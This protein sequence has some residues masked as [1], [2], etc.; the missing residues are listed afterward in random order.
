MWDYNRLG[1]PINGIIYL[2][3]FCVYNKWLCYLS[4]LFIEIHRAEAGIY[5]LAASSSG[6]LVHGGPG[7]VLQLHDHRAPPN[8]QLSLIGHKDTIRSIL[9]N[10]QDPNNCIISASS[11]S[12]VKIWDARAAACVS[13][14][15][16]ESSVWC[17]E[18]ATSTSVSMDVFWAGCRD[19]S[20]IK[21]GRGTSGFPSSAKITPRE[22]HNWKVI[23][24]NENDPPAHSRSLSGTVPT[25]LVDVG[26]RFDEVEGVDCVLIC[27]EDS[28]VTKIC[29]V[30]GSFIWTS[31]TSSNIN[32]WVTSTRIIDFNFNIERLAV[33][34]SPSSSCGR[35]SKPR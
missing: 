34:K 17:L 4:Y 10:N 20:V 23:D 21:V 7:G 3:F 5:A 1:V 15:G 25:A 29:G 31:T 9:I 8:P 14:L 19:G 28:P 35:K 33:R 13:T 16:F 2:I 27:K 26:G 22:T 18:N 30:D 24:D 32:R 6:I 12:T 11:D